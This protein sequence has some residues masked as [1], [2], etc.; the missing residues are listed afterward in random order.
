MRRLRLAFDATRDLYSTDPVLVSD[1][2]ETLDADFRTTHELANLAK[3]GTWIID[4]NLE[5]L[6]TADANFLS[7]FPAQLS[8]LP[9]AV[10]ELF[11]AIK[12]QRAVEALMAK[13]PDTGSEEVIAE[14][15]IND[16]EDRLR[17]RLGGQELTAAD[18]TFVASVRL[19]QGAL[20]EDTQTQID[21]RKFCFAR[22]WE[23]LT[24]W[25][26]SLS[27]KYPPTDLLRLFS[28]CVKDRLAL[29]TSLGEK[30]GVAIPISDDVAE[31][32][33]EPV[34][35]DNGDDMML[36][37]DD[38]SSFFEKTTSGLVQNALAGLT[39][40]E[41]TPAPTIEGEEAPVEVMDSTPKADDPSPHTNGKVD[42]MTDYKELEALV[43]ESTA[44][45]VK[46]TLNGLSPVPYQPTVPASTGKSHRH[47]YPGITNLS[48]RE[49]GGAGSVSEPSST[50]TA[51]RLLFV[52]AAS[53]GTSSPAARSWRDSATQ[54]V[55][56]KR[57]IV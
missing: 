26:V 52:L 12:T 30:L 50:A 18:Q 8:E 49:H 9:L 24:I 48:S 34:P 15:L 11:L 45:Y 2:L 31:V 35:E 33:A 46:T 43:A 7:V 25:Q 40:E 13:G 19:R 1:P 27:A 28:R 32:E 42:F 53:A 54:S 23:T 16:L 6:A 3:L 10:S 44:D 51:Q 14:A 39:E 22:E 41:P 5:S 17:G 38:L 55:F 21:Q 57:V 37:L 36:D 47:V 20:R 29:A 56:V 4:G